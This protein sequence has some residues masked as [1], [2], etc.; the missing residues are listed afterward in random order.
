MSLLRFADCYEWGASV[1]TDSVAADM[2]RE[3]ALR[4]GDPAAILPELRRYASRRFARA[5]RTKIDL[6]KAIRMAEALAPRSPE[7]VRRV[8]AWKQLVP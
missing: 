7:A 6:P 5:L 1:K 8:E 2:L 3:K 4:E